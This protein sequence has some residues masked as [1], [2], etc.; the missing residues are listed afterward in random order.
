MSYGFVSFVA[1]FLV[2]WAIVVFIIAAEAIAEEARHAQ[3][4]RPLP[5]RNPLKGDRQDEHIGW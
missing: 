2:M 3:Q 4:T 5:G 1:V